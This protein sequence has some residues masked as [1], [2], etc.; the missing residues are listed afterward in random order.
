MPPNPTPPYWLRAT[1]APSV[2]VSEPDADLEAL[3]SYEPVPSR[4]R[5]AQQSLVLLLGVFFV[6]TIC[7]NL[8]PDESSV[9]SSAEATGIPAEAVI[10]SLAAERREHV[11][12]AAA[13]RALEA[14]TAGAPAS[15]QTQSQSPDDK[16]GSKSEQGQSATT[17]PGDGGG[18]GGGGGQT[19]DDGNLT[20]PLV[21][22][23][24]LSEPETKLPLVDDAIAEVTSTD[25]LSEPVTVLP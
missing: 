17:Q 4:P 9:A 24:P 22:E 18:G 16:A 12:R 20:L 11:A 1:P 5:S 10:A 15:G 2:P 14:V 3:D 23:T 6:A 21:G 19:S 13:I 8:W 7:V 25:L